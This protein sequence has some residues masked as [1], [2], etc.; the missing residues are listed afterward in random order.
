MQVKSF[1]PSMACYIKLPALKNNF[2]DIW[3]D[4]LKW[5]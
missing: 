1:A 2:G 3:L 4:M 5:V